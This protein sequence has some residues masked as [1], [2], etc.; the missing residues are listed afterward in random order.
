MITDLFLLYYMQNEHQRIS[1]ITYLSYY[2]IAHNLL[3]IKYS[4]EFHTPLQIRF[5]IYRFYLLDNLKLLVKIVI[6]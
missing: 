3:I 2:I 5:D 1:L 6:Q 4:I